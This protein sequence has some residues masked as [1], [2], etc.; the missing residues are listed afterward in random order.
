MFGL[1]L[2]G[3]DIVSTPGP[4]MLSLTILGTIPAGQ[5]MRRRGARS[6]DLLCV[7]GS[8]GEAAMGLRIL[9]GLAATED[10]ALPLIDRYRTPRPRLTL[11]RLLR[12]RASAAI[13][14][15]DGL[16]ADLS[17]LLDASG[18]GAVVDASRLPIA[19][20]MAGLPG[21]L[22]S[23]LGGGDDYE[24][25]FTFPSEHEAQIADLAGQADVR[26]SVIGRIVEKPGLEVVD[27]D[28]KP[29]HPAHLGWTHF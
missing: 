5:A 25:L 17:H 15:S 22:E 7:S 6:G 26:I 9:R 27:R 21:A 11:G 12:G 19:P 14:V 3:G 24:L 1:H 2:I 28:G 10:E 8:L 18:V 4:L 23:A 13:D 29:L 16:L 20:P